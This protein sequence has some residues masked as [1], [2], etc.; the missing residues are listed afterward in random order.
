[1]ATT[2]IWAIKGTAAAIRRVEMYIENP[3]KTIEQTG[4]E[5]QSSLHQID[6]NGSMI[7]EYSPEELEQE[8]VCYVSGINCT[9]PNDACEEFAAV[10]DLGKALQRQSVLPWLSVLPGRR[11]HRRASTRDRRE[12][13]RAAVGRSVS[14]C[15]CNASEYRS[16][17]QSHHAQCHRLCRWVQ[18]C[19]PQV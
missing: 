7:H 1:M 19:Q 11:S 16:L 14:G 15:G 4:L 5:Y 10:Y 18:I 3:E 12:T 8:K 17:S 13:G 9:A 2:S 6:Q